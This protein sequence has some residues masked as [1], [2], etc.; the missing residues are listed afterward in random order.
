MSADPHAQGA[1]LQSGVEPGAA[2]LGLVLAH[3]R[4]GSARDIMGLAG[5]SGQSDIAVAAPEAM[6]N[7]WWPVSFLAPLHDLDPWLGS[8]LEA[9]RR[10]VA[11]LEVGGLPRERIVLAGFS[12]GAC[13]AAEF[14]AR[15]GGRWAG[16]AVLSGA[17]VGTHDAGDAPDQ[18]LYGHTPKRFDYDRRLDGVPVYFGCHAQDPHIPRARVEE[19]AGV[20]RALGA[21][22]EMSIHPGA[23]HG[24]TDADL[25]AFRDLVAGSGHPK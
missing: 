22:V 4:G 5:A 24:I 18:A 1:L 12:Q 8:A 14:A 7:S 25:E 10:A 2:R 20:M 13:L 21:Q 9:M 19:S 6:G 11:S 3:G 16:L 17:L 15:E 23:G